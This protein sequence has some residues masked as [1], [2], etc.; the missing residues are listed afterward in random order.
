MDSYIYGMKNFLLLL[1]L[2]FVA[3]QSGKESDKALTQTATEDVID[4]SDIKLDIY[5]FNGLEKYLNIK[6]DKTYV[7]NFW[8]TWCAPCVKELPY[9]EALNKNYKDKDVEVMLV[10]LDFPKQY[11]KK[12]KPF[13]KEHNLQS[14]ILVLDDTDMNTWI[15]KVNENWDGAI[16]VTLI[17]NKDLREFY[18]QPFTYEQLETEIKRFLK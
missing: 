17:Y 6:D 5:D 18:A 14:K 1:I 2:L 9:F 7:V 12:L 16:P 3:C 11:E 8:A 15:P 4:T 10:S 13:I